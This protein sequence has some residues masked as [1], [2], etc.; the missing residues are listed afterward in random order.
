LYHP[1]QAAIARRTSAKSVNVRCHTHSSLRERKNRSMSPFCSGLYGVMNS[2]RSRHSWQAARKRRLWKMRPLSLRR[3]GVTS[4]GRR[5]PKR[6]RQ[7]CSEARS[8]F[9]AR[10]RRAN[11]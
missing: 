9:R 5:V 11:S 2:W 10:P 8:A 3:T 6:A 7:A 1:I 4:V